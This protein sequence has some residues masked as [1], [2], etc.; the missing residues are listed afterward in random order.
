[1]IFEGVVV[2]VGDYYYGDMTNNIENISNK[3]KRGDS[4]KSSSSTRRV[5]EWKVGPNPE[6]NVVQEVSTLHAFVGLNASYV[7]EVTDSLSAS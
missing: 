3:R 6:E 5:M 2:V 4:T 1:M 7:L